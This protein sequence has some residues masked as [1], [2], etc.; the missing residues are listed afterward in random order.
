MAAPKFLLI[1]GAPYGGA[2]SFNGKHE[3]I[4]P[5]L[6]KLGIDVT[7]IDST[8]LSATTGAVIGYP[9]ADFDG[10]VFNGPTSASAA[11]KKFLGTPDVAH[12]WPVLT[13]NNDE[14]C[15]DATPFFSGVVAAGKE[16]LLDVMLKT[17]V[18]TSRVVAPEVKAAGKIA[19]TAAATIVDNDKFTLTTSL[20]SK[21]YTFTTNGDLAG[22]D[23]Y[24]YVFEESLGDAQAVATFIG[25]ALANTAVTGADPGFTTDW[26]ESFVATELYF[27]LANGATSISIGTITGSRLTWTADPVITAEAVLDGDIA[28][29]G[30]YKM[31]GDWE[32]ATPHGTYTHIAD[33]DDGSKLWPI[34]W[35]RVSVADHSDVIYNTVRAANATLNG[36]ILASVGWYL[37]ELGLTAPKPITVR[38]DIDDVQDTPDTNCITELT[39]YLRAKGTKA[40]CGIYPNTA[41]ATWKSSAALAAMKAA[42]DCYDWIMH[43]HSGAGAVVSQ[44]QSEAGDCATITGKLAAAEDGSIN[45]GASTKGRADIAT[46]TGLGDRLRIFT[47]DGYMYFPSNTVTE[48]SIK[49]LLMLGV[50]YF[51]RVST[52]Y[53]ASVQRVTFP[54]HD[55][56]GIAIDVV[57]PTTLVGKIVLT[58]GITGGSNTAHVTWTAIKGGVVGTS[59]TDAL[60]AKDAQYKLARDKG[61]WGGVQRAMF[62]GPTLRKADGYNFIVDQFALSID[63]MIAFTGG[64]VIRWYRPYEAM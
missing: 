47:V 15:V 43:D 6:R 3:A 64:T 63:P 28:V 58:Q 44:W 10:C 39:A 1:M 45:A 25:L 56:I 49:A 51:A 34:V 50:K 21:V 53:P 27:E 13:I 61:A 23:G 38:L 12:P 11:T 18:R 14:T 4:L 37:N 7:C 35:R 19:L 52:L 16:A 24:V 46:E 57:N 22:T 32:A 55:D 17:A 9:E 2:G 60:Y 62:H 36:I 31:T 41:Y 42:P 48:L 33:Y 5:L 54:K 30:A 29:G 26:S 8:Q 20:G 40:T 59:A